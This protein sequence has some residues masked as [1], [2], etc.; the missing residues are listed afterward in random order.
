MN[1]MNIKDDSKQIL[2]KIQ[3]TYKI[4]EIAGKD[5]LKNLQFLVQTVH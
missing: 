2:I 5:R 4:L 3:V 1:A